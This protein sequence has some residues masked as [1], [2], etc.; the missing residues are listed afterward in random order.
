MPLSPRPGPH[1]SASLVSSSALNGPQRVS[2]PIARWLLILGLSSLSLISPV[3]LR[4]WVLTET[5]LRRSPLM[6]AGK[7]VEMPVQA[8]LNQDGTSESLDVADGGLALRSGASILWRSPAEWTV[9]Q[10]GITDL[11]LDGRPEVSLLVWRSFEALPTDR[12][13]P[14]AGRIDSF[15]DSRGQS[16]HL[17]LIGWDGQG[18]LRELWAGSALADPITSFTTADLDQ[19]GRQELLTLEHDYD[20]PSPALARDLKVWEW[21]G[22]GFTA[23]AATPGRLLRLSVVGGI[24]GVEILGQVD[25]QAMAGVPA[26]GGPR[27]PGR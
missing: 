2:S 13:L 10:A 11:N 24:E 25:I 14:H 1:S 9:R 22:F 23:I 6:S 5:G 26:D 15:H 3:S 19:D 7:P 27:I 21:N 8:D 16:C 4:S 20:D 18:R 17:I 12:L